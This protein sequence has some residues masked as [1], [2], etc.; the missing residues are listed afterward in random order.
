MLVVGLS[1][2]GC[3]SD[4]TRPPVALGLVVQDLVVGNGAV[5]ERGDTI[6]VNY[7]GWLTDSTLFDSSWRHGPMWF[8]LGTGQLIRGWDL[9]MPGTR[10]GGTRR[11]VIPSEYAYGEQGVPG[12]IPANATLV[13]EVTLYEVRSPRSR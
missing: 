12:V 8:V 2:V 9:G 10:E 11:L 5:A 3:G 7:S 1:L 6:V 13:Y 4:V